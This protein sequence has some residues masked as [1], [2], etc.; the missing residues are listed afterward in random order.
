[1]RSGKPEQVR[2]NECLKSSFSRQCWPDQSGT[3]KKQEDVFGAA[4]A[5]QV[6]GSWVPEER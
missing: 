1:M 4:V 3:K 5:S 6:R 2:P